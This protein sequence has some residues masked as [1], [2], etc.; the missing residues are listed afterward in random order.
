VFFICISRSGFSF[1]CWFGWFVVFNPVEE[2]VCEES[3][4]S[5]AT[6]LQAEYR[7]EEEYIPQAVHRGRIRRCQGKR[8]LGRLGIVNTSAL[9]TKHDLPEKSVRMDPLPWCHNILLPAQVV[10]QAVTQGAV[11]FVAALQNMTE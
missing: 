3:T 4:L 10:L 9:I 6:A 1:L 11:A 8:G 5:E 2:G 7:R